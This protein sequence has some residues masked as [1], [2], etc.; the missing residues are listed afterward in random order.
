M[1]HMKGL[2]KDRISSASCEKSRVPAIWDKAAGRRPEFGPE[3]ILP[4]EIWSCL[5][6]EGRS[7]M[8]T[9]SLKIRSHPAK[10]PRLN[11]RRTTSAKSPPQN[12][13]TQQSVRSKPVALG[14]LSQS[15]GYRIRRAQLW[16]FKDVSRKLA[17]FD[18]S[19]AQFSVLSVIDSNP[20]VNQ[21]AIAQVLSIERAGLGRLV[22]NLERRGLVA[23][24]ASSTNRRYYL[25]HLTRE[26]A[27]LL[28]RLR[29][30]VAECEKSLAEKI[31]SRAYTQLQ[32]TLSIFLDE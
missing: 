22:D 8:Q 4:T 15:L 21:L 27:A 17:S 6:G 29:P 24:A 1:K 14:D 16:V 13:E 32:Q 28:G 26:G 12:E 31:G 20:G 9:R 7:T 3:G 5:A 19:P 23:R 2:M 30:I 18:I 25:L 10:R 11:A